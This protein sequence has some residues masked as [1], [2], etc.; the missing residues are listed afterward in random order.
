MNDA[1]YRD[2]ARV[3]HMHFALARL[4][5][6]FARI[7]RDTFVEGN[8]AAET[9]LYNLTILGEAA[10]NVSR[11]YCAAHPEVDFKDMAGL[12]HRLIHDYANIDMDRI[13]FILLTDVPLWRE[14]VDA[15]YSTIPPPPT[16]L[17]PNVGEFD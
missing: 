12:R 6:V 7:T 5:E 16:E 1:T 3:E 2:E 11:E 17:P 14:T 15:L 9:I 8:D 10:N 4:A 13:W